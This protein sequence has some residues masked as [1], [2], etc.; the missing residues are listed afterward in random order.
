MSETTGRISDA[1]LEVMKV[2]WESE[3]ALT[4][5]QLVDALQKER[6][7]SPTT[8][9]T[10]VKRLVEKGAVQ[11]EKRGVFCYTPVITEEALAQERAADLVNKVFGGNAKDLVSTL[12]TGDILSGEDLSELEDYWKS[13]REKK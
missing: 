4:E 3:A 9:K 7:W 1:E 12:L 11:R 10:L 5:R 8:I 6:D 2:L 13:R